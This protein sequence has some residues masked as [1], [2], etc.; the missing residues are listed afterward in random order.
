MLNTIGA[1]VLIGLWGAYV[2]ARARQQQRVRLSIDE[3]LDTRP[4]IQRI[5]IQR[6][7]RAS[8]YWHDFP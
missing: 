1:V 6:D 7:R 4:P 8:T 5:P 3:L 2:A